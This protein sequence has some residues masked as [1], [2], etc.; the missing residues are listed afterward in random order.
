MKKLNGIEKTDLFQ[1]KCFDLLGE[2]ERLNIW[3]DPIDPLASITQKEIC[4]L[5]WRLFD[6]LRKKQRT[7]LAEY[8]SF[9]YLASLDLFLNAHMQED[10]EN[11]VNTQVLGNTRNWVTGFVDSHPAF[12]NWKYTEKNNVAGQVANAV[13]DECENNKAD[14]D[15]CAIAIARVY[16]SYQTY[17]N[18][19][20][21]VQFS[22][23][24]EAMFDKLH[25]VTLQLQ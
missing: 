5:H 18:E 6:S 12:K 4:D 25:E 23:A 22:K 15:G 21:A 7:S 11:C 3:F 17:L 19:L 14:C 24:S 8:V 1:S 10:M 20:F 13:N 16:L 2:D 9:S